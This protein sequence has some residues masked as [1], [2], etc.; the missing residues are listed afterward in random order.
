MSQY[1]LVR[2]QNAAIP[3]SVRSTTETESLVGQPE[4]TVDVSPLTSGTLPGSS[5][6]TQVVVSTSVPDLQA[7]TDAFVHLQYESQCSQTLHAL[8]VL[9]VHGNFG[10]SI[11]QLMGCVIEEVNAL[12]QAPAVQSSIRQIRITAAVSF[13]LP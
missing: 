10:G 7:R 8:T 12:R 1:E 4:Q 2:A 11:H 5:L 6:S 13:L 3:G 9:K